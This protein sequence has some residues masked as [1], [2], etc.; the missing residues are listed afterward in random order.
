MEQRGE[1]GGG[2]ERHRKGDLFSLGT[3]IWYSAAAAAAAAPGQSLPTSTHHKADTPALLKE[4]HECP[5]FRKQ[6]GNGAVPGRH[7]L[8]PQS[9]SL[10][11][12]RG[13]QSAEVTADSYLHVEVGGIQDA[14]TPQHGWEFIFLA[15]GTVTASTAVCGK[16][17]RHAR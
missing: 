9:I 16:H 2:C 17:Q 10:S 14:A 11:A 6:Y 13:Q 3:S 7:I 1:G 15:D 5:V 8:D 4:P 12:Y